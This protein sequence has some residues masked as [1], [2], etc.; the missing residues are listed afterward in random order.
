ML[1]GQLENAVTAN[2]QAWELKASVSDGGHDMTSARILFTR[3]SLEWLRGSDPSVCVGQ[4][5]NLMLRPSLPSHGGVS[6][7]WDAADILDSLRPKLLPWQLD[8]LEAIVERL[9]DRNALTEL[10]RFLAWSDQPIVTL[11]TRWPSIGNA[12]N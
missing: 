3:I 4:L 6:A 10:N 5:H 7:V 9:N 2:A 12:R 11:E 8:L 1:A